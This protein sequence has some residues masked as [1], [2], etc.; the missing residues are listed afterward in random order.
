MFEPV[1]WNWLILAA[2]FLIVEAFTV[3]FFFLLWAMAAFAMAGL[4]ALMPALPWPWQA[5]WFFVFSVVCLAAWYGIARHW[6][7]SG[8][9]DEAAQLNNRGLALIG[10]QFVLQEAVHEQ[11]GRLQIDDSLWTVYS[12]VDLPAGTKIRIARIESTTL[13]VEAVE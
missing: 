13:H 6:R 5:L 9:R 12:P 4:T 10:R 11:Y 1:F 8:T 3:S 7:K 2:V